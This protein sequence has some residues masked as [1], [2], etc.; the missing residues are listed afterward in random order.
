M[1]IDL[2]QSQLF[3]ID[4][5]LRFAKEYGVP[6][7]T[8]K[9]LWGRYKLLDYSNGDLRDYLFVKHARNISYTSMT[10]WINRTEVYERG[11]AIL[12]M[13]AKMANT[14]VFGDFEQYV[15]DEITKN[16]RASV[17]SDSRAII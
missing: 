4:P 8:W 5:D 6:L 10:R 1:I 12:S 7:G 14:N 3:T 11:M 16:M 13:G 9:T 2:S 17:S 15:L